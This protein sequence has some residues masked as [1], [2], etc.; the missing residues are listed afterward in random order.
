[1]GLI[2]NYYKNFKRIKNNR[3]IRI[4]AIF[5]ININKENKGRK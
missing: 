3:I 2:K 1:M 5:N 4:I